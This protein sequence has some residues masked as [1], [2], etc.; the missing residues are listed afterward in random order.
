MN[1]GDT[2]TPS[3]TITAGASMAAPTPGYMKATYSGN[4]VSKIYIVVGQG[5]EEAVSNSGIYSVGT[6]IY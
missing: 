5:V 2:T 6:T 3:T 1:T 4:N